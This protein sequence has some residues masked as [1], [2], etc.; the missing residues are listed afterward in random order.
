MAE[1]SEKDA[2]VAQIRIW[3]Y[4]LIDRKMAYHTQEEDL[5]V[6]TEKFDACVQ[7]LQKI[8][9]LKFQLRNNIEEETDIIRCEEIRIANLKKRLTKLNNK[10]NE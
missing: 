2:L 7:E 5:V 6:Q 1:I 9:I 8:A 4:A 3:E 10:T